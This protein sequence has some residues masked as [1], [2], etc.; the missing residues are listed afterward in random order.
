MALCD[1]FKS[2][3]ADRSRRCTAAIKVCE[4]HPSY[5]KKVECNPAD[6][7]RR[8][9]INNEKHLFDF[10]YLWQSPNKQFINV[11]HASLACTMETKPYNISVVSLLKVLA[12]EEGIWQMTPQVVS[13]CGAERVNLLRLS[14][15]AEARGRSSGSGLYV[16]LWRAVQSFADM[17]I[18]SRHWSYAGSR[19]L[20]QFH[21][22]CQTLPAAPA[23]LSK[24]IIPYSRDWDF[25]RPQ[26]YPK[27]TRIFPFSSIQT[28]RLTLP[29]YRLTWELPIWWQHCMT[30]S[31][32]FF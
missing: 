1:Q 32:S 7:I 21:H 17:L 22:A 28:Y 26:L 10:K 3:P 13:L 6:C 19:A 31:I 16:L 12:H 5:C 2:R 14:W 20:L 25:L 15:I 9:Q 27:R 23:N 11:S 30:R 24:V 29:C 8:H 18:L 4:T